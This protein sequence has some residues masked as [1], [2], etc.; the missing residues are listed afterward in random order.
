MDKINM[1]VVIGAFVSL[2]ATAPD[3]MMALFAV[4]AIGVA[5]A[6]MRLCKIA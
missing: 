2:L 1:C 6:N 5:I 3:A 4:S